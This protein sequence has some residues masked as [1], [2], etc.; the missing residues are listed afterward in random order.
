MNT[1]ALPRTDL[2]H[3]IERLAFC[4]YAGEDR[5]LLRGM[6]LEPSETPGH[7]R[8][9]ATDGHRMGVADVPV[10]DGTPARGVTLPR[11]AV[12]L[13]RDELSSQA[14]MTAT[15]SLNEG[16]FRIECGRLCVGADLVA[17]PYPDY[18]KV[19]DASKAG[20]FAVTVN[21]G[22]L[23]DA[24]EAVGQG[25][26]ERRLSLQIKKS[27]IV[28]S[29]DDGSVAS[30]PCTTPQK[31]KPFK[32]AFNRLYLLDALEPLRGVD[33]TLRLQSPSNP[34]S[35]EAASIPGLLYV[36]M[37]LSAKRAARTAKHQ[38]QGNTHD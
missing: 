30:V 20:T 8:C 25:G 28:I 15:V 12:L 34:A 18:R 21:A 24:A 4:M 23:F 37:P 35:F 9:V 11:W 5:L 27:R 31:W 7:I 3:A 29:S 1:F 22:E 36:V 32:I 13:L 6:L 17:L 16:C 2:L 38:Q 19:V 26:D 14:E 33:A 10:A